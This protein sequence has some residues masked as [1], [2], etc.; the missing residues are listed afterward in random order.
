[1]KI[2]ITGGAGFIGSHIVD[3]YVD[4]GF[5]VIVYDNFSSGSN[6]NI[7][8]HISN[9]SIEIIRGDI[10]DYELLNKSMK[11]VDYVSHHAAQ[12]EIFLAYEDPMKDLEVNT[13]GTLNVLKAAK[14]NSVK[15]V[16][17]VS[18]ACVYGQ[19]NG[20]S[21]ESDMLRPNWDYGVSKLAA[22]K[23]G[24]IYN[25]YKGL[26][27]VN[28]RYSIVY[29]EREWYRRALPIFL[30]RIIQNEPPVIFGNG[31]QERDFIYVKDVVDINIKCL[32]NDSINGE[33]FNVGSGTKTSIKEL[34]YSVCKLNGNTMPLFE[35]TKEGEFS[36][37]IPG[38]K[39]NSSELQTM[40]LNIE[41]ANNL[42]DWHPKTSLDN[43]LLSEYEWAK[44]NID[45]W[46]KIFST[47]W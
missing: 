44:K 20:Q 9:K 15:K 16:I 11:N 32:E 26:P 18:S 14:N 13:I 40:F 17:N 37:L 43:G 30:K 2:L 46:E 4:K 35:D 21:V 23:Y 47:Q 25:D 38:K 31:D 34:A 41:K 29:G 6:F 45:R 8:R 12:L 24:C 36:N 19:V 42:L 27:V 1:M 22:E 3:A 5:D 10:L 7:S 33:I 28:L 39:R